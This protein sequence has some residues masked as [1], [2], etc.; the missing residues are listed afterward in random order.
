MTPSEVR[1]FAPGRVNLIGEHTDYNRGLAL[2]FAIAEGVTVRARARAGQR[3]CAHA[4]D[5]GER[6]EFAPADLLPAHDE[7]ARVDPAPAK[8]RDPPMPSAPRGAGWRA[9]VRGIA[10]EL[11][12]AG[13]ALG[14]ADLEIHG[15]VPRN[16][17]LS[18][19]AALEVSL[20]L[21]LLGIAGVELHGD[22]YAEPGRGGRAPRAI[23]DRRELAR[24]CSRVEHEWLGAHTGLLDQLASLYGQADTA[25]R[26]DFADLDIQPVPLVLA[27]GW[28]LVT[29]DSGDPRALAASGYN[30]RRAE[31]A[32]AC[33]LLGVE[34]LRD[35]RE[36]NLDRLP[37]VLARRVRHVLGENARVLETVAALHRGA[38]EDVGALLDAS[39]ASLR[40]LYECSTPAVEVA[41]RALREAGAL[42]ARMV[43]GGFGGHVLGLFPP[44]SSPP[45]RACEVRPSRGAHL[46]A[47]GPS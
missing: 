29:L 30:E 37:P 21:A 20:A 44:G 41:V 2:P 1:A 45:A 15:E 42:G 19:S 6:D 14:G 12:G 13:V 47:E 11:L 28:R 22:A 17:G 10:A 26:I 7:L 8:D 39:H 9:F 16:A 31:C 24:L 40:D 34:S 27:D 25:L 18:S 4:L 33:A 23:D 35:A 5:L 32:R 38:L 3:I 46:L 43:G 36:P